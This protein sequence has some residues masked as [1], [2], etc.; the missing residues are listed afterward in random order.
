M[1]NDLSNFNT[2]ARL[3][4]ELVELEVFQG[5]LSNRSNLSTVSGR[6]PWHLEAMPST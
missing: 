5:R 3:S 2:R 6:A 4:K 1:T